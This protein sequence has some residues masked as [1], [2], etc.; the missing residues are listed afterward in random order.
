MSRQSAL[1]G[2]FNT[3]LLGF[4]AG[5]VAQ[6]V[7]GMAAGGPAPAGVSVSDGG[8]RVIY[9]P[10]YFA[11]YNVVTARDQLER[12]PGL[13]GVLDG[14]AG[15]RQRGFGNSGDQVLINGKRLSGKT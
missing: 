7:E 8:N 9:G 6:E 13:Q 11:R 12:I 4:E 10:D 15:G 5:S 1:L 14:G 2:L 3:A